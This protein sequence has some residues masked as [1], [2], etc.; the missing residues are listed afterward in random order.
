MAA[1]PAHKWPL[2]AA[3]SAGAPDLN[4]RMPEG[5]DLVAEGAGFE[6]AIR[7]PVYTLSRRAPSTARPPLR[8]SARA[9]LMT[10]QGGTWSSRG[11]GAGVWSWR[12]DTLPD[13][14]VPYFT[15]LTTSP[16]SPD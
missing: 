8:S 1:A 5:R 15:A 7:F 14:P 11:S 16:S 13:L 9:G 3:H 12:R 10:A 6:P 4:G 2:T